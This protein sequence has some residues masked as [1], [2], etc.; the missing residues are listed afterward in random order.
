MPGPYQDL[1]NLPVKI[2]SGRQFIPAQ[3]EQII[4][5]NIRQNGALISDGD[6]EPLVERAGS[7]RTAEVDHICPASLG[8]PNSNPN[9]CLPS[10]GENRR[11]GNSGPFVC[12]KT[13]PVTIPQPAR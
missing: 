3:R 9:A 12:P 6:R 7:D 2:D 13:V 5:E 10:R 11:K 4:A 8:G 1:P